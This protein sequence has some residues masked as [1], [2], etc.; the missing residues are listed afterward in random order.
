MAKGD[1]VD[2]EE[3]VGRTLA[4]TPTSVQARDEGSKQPQ[5]GAHN[6]QVVVGGGAEAVLW[7]KETK[8]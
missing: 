8:G 5:Q 3:Q 1:G 7:G 4:T 6:S 2:R